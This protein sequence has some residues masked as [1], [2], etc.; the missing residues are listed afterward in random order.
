MQGLSGAVLCLSLPT[1][2]VCRAI[3]FRNFEI[4]IQL[5]LLRLDSREPPDKKVSYPTVKGGFLLPMEIRKRVSLI[6]KH[7]QEEDG[8][9]VK[10]GG[11]SLLTSN[12]I[13]KMFRGL[14][15]NI[16][17][18]CAPGKKD[19]LLLELIT[20]MENYKHSYLQCAKKNSLKKPPVPGTAKNSASAPLYQHFQPRNTSPTEQAGPGL[21]LN[22]ALYILRSVQSVATAASADRYQVVHA[23]EVSL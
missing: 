18:L 15:S 11:P 9:P 13:N 2:H 22:R 20:V 23:A 1:D 19:S 12:T 3:V 4:P 5:P 17:L 6:P 7:S 10:E 8:F 21:S 16:G 14:A